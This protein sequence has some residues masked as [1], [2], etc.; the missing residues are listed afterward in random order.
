MVQSRGQNHK[1]PASGQ[2][3]DITPGVWG[4][5]N[6]LRAGDKISNGQIGYIDQACNFFLRGKVV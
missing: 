4:V 3:G 6:A 1:R 2:I 5:P